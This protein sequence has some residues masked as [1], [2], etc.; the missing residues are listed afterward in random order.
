MQSR[1][2]PSSFSRL[3]IPELKGERGEK[4]EL[5][6]KWWKKGSLEVCVSGAL[7]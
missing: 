5:F 2:R 3:D 7:S 4:K 6:K 1:G